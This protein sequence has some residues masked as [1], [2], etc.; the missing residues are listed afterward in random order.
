MVVKVN[1]EFGIELALVVPY[2]YY[3]HAQGKLDKV[4]TSKGMK[5]FYYFCDN[6]EERY[7]YRTIDNSAAGLDELPNNWIHGI[8]SMGKPGVLDYREWETPPYRDHYKN[9]E[10][11]FNGKIVF[12]T[13]KYNIEKGH[14]PYG[15]FNIKCLYDMFVYLT[16]IGYTVI[17]KRPLNTEF[18][19]DQHELRTSISNMNILSDVEGIGVLS[20]R[21]LPKYFNDVYLFDD[22]VDKYSYNETQMKI[23]ANTDYFISQSGGNTILSCMWDRPVITY[24]TQGKELRPNYFSKDSYFQKL[25]NQKCFPVYDVIEEINSSSHDHKLN[26]TG[27][28]NYDG[29]LKTIKEMIIGV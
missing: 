26:K 23:M 2:A 1:P 15:Y 19:V 22:L 16:S 13:N 29:L 9:N 20:D 11:T 8:D 5:P 27:K 7:D 4:V 3:L 24:L 17:Y 18:V 6:V 12:I 14:K 21:D 25:S 10:Y 28:N